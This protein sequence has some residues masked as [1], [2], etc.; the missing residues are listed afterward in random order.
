M[1]KHNLPS[2]ERAGQGSGPNLKFLPNFRD[3]GLSAGKYIGRL[4]K[5]KT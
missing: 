2:G 1:V 4:T 5:R 3:W